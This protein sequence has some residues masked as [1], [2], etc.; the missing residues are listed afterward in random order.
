MTSIRLEKKQFEF[1]GRVWEICCNMAVL[2]AMQEAH[3]GDFGE[4]MNLPIL[5]A[6]SEILAAMLNDYAEDMGWEVRY[7]PKQIAKQ[8]PFSAMRELDIVGMFTRAV[9]PLGSTPATAEDPGN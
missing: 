5:Q 2:E 8:V 3:G 4:V 1:D 7:T 9:I 6:P